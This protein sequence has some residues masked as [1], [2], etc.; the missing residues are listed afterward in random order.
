MR[1]FPRSLVAPAV[2][3]ATLLPSAAEPGIRLDR[4]ISGLSQPLLVT[5]AGDGS[6]R[7]FVVQQDGVIR[8]W[9]DGGLLAQ[10]FL[11]LRDRVTNRGEMG[12]LGLT[13]H[14]D[15]AENRRF[16]V[17]YTTDRNGPRRTVVSEFRVLSDG[18]A[19]SSSETILLAIAQPAENHN[20]GML[21]FGPD[22]LLYIATGDGGGGGDPFANGQNPKTLLGAILRIDVDRGNP[23]EIPPENPFAAGVGGAP[24]VWAWGLRNPWRFSFDRLTGLLFAGDVGQNAWEEVDIIRRGGNY[25]WN[26]MEGF[27]CFPAGSSCDPSG[28]ALPVTEYG[29]DE[30]RSVTG[31]YVYRGQRETGLWGAYL[32]GDFASGRIWSLRPGPTGWQRRLLLD[33]ELQIASFGEDEDGELYV[34][35]YGG[36]VYR[37]QF[38]AKTYFAHFADGSGVGGSLRSVLLLAN[39]R[40]ETVRSLVRFRTGDGEARPMAT[41]QGTAAELVVELPPTGSAVLATTGESAPLYA[42]WAEIESDV[43]VASNLLF[44]FAA[45][46]GVLAEAGVGPSVPA[47]RFATHFFR[48]TSDGLD[49]GV[50]LANPGGSAAEVTL[51]VFG[52][53]GILAATVVPLPP[54]GH[55]AAFLSE[56]AEL[57]PVVEGSLLVTSDTPVIATVLRTQG[58]RPSASLPLAP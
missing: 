21:A 44:Q 23:Y 56:L 55:R 25:G 47:E 26:R 43:P 28:F 17:N 1:P 5:H 6:G 16:F 51:T 19:D 41:S 8:T 27:H 40:S 9:R 38:V 24:E 52:E 12:L 58:G 42:G 36:E 57:P 29:R 22:G 48:D 3:L 2:V 35:H 10:P 20:G 11:D 53:E 50:A 32:F 4:L 46:G 33:T 14:P 45:R 13:F 15:F 34:V 49:T 37:L 31:G 39:G 7:L 54:F 30:G 18:T